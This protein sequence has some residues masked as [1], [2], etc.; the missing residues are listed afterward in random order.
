MIDSSKYINQ[1]VFTSL[2]R[3]R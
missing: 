1:A 3:S 2:L